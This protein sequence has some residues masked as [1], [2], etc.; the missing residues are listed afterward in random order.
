[1]LTSCERKA[2]EI[3]D[4]SLAGCASGGT[5]KGHEECDGGEGADEDHEPALLVR[6]PI[7]V[8]L[9]VV[10]QLLAPIPRQRHWDE[11]QDEWSADATGVRDHDLGVSLEHDDDNDG[12][13]EDD[14]PDALHTA[15]MVLQSK[16]KQKSSI[17]SGVQ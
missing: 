1:M 15:L 4:R 17:T 12:D 9:V 2:Q 11:E 14:R 6:A 10:A 8:L 13:S 3:P 5:V 16:R 7:E